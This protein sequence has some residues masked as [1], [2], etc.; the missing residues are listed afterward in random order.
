[1]QR[2]SAIIIFVLLL[3][4][5]PAFAFSEQARIKNTL[6]TNNKKELLI[7]FRVDGCFTPKIEEAIQSGIPT[8]F[9]YRVNLYNKSGDT[10]GTEI[11]SRRISHTIKYDPLKRDYTLT[12]SERKEPVVIQDFKA[13]KDVMATVDAFPLIPLDR[14]GK[15]TQYSLQV[16]AEM[17]TI[18]LPPLLN[19]LFF[20]V[21]YWNFET[22][23]ETVEFTY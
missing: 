23:W 8:T 13:A 18:K 2:P 14:L 22:A 5:S 16:K 19:Y 17:D 4:L 7:Y 12:M 20:F 10:L 3:I 21:S 6:I 9:I 15:D 11:K 1:M